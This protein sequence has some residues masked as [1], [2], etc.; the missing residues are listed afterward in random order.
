MKK[1]YS[2]SST[3]IDNYLWDVR[4]VTRNTLGVDNGDRV[5]YPLT[6]YIF[7]GRASLDFLHKLIE[8]SP[9]RI[10]RLLMGGGSD[11]YIMDRI[12]RS[13]KFKSE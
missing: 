7:T 4:T 11:D 2:I 12:K 3:G 5:M 10:A 8:V 13:I 9:A 1:T 6:Y